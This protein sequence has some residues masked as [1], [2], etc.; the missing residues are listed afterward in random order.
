M[1]RIKKEKLKISTKDILYFLVLIFYFESPYLERFSILNTLYAVGKLISVGFILLHI[2]RFQFNSIMAVIVLEE[3]TLWISTLLAGSSMMAVS[4]QVISVTAFVVVIDIMLKEDTKR[5]IRILYTIVSLLIFVNVLTMLFFPDGLYT[6]T[7]IVGTKKYY[8]LGHQNSLGLYAMIAIAL[9]EFR[10]EIEEEDEFKLS[11]LIFLEIVSLFYILR[12]W[13]VI[14]LLSVAGII[15]ITFF[16]RLSKKGWHFPLA[17]SLI[18]NVVIFIVFV[19]IQNFQMLAPFLEGVLNR[20]VTLS[21]RTTVWTM[22]LKYFFK[23][24]I[25]GV[26]QG[27]GY[28][29]F[30]FAT[31]HNRYMNTLFTGGLI[32]IFPF[33]ILLIIIC[34]RLKNSTESMAKILIAYFTILL[35]IIQGETFDDIL[36]YMM[37]MFAGNVQYLVKAKKIYRK[38]PHIV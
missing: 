29:I 19:V 9:G 2:R 8:F 17:W 30:G 15:A 10:L 32:G 34:R 37:F 20:E 5:C 7:G 27:K 21:G 36:F 3:I 1:I 6:A 28:E 23:S 31:T 25:W 4:I 11:K 33:V 35:F 12:V 16:N 24:P 13:S 14:S 38:N 26:G 22:A 18:F